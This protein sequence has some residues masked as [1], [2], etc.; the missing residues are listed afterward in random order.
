[1]KKEGITPGHRSGRFQVVRDST[2]YCCPHINSPLNIAP[3]IRYLDVAS[4]H[5]SAG[6]I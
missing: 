5:Q 1:M 4:D 6:E 3:D 2:A